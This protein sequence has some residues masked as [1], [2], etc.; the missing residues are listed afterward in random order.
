MKPRR[1]YRELGNTALVAAASNPKVI[2]AAGKAVPVVM[3]QQ[4]R[5]VNVGLIIT[6]TIVGGI[7]LFFLSR[8]AAKKQRERLLREAATN[9]NKKA[10]LDIFAAIPGR[11]KEDETNLFNPGK[12]ISDWFNNLAFWQ[13]SDSDRI[14]LVA[15]RITDL[16]ETARTFQILYGEALTPLLQKAMA[17]EDYDRFL[18]SAKRPK[19]FVQYSSSTANAGKIAGT[20]I[21]TTLLAFDYRGFKSYTIAAN[22]LINGYTTGKIYVDQYGQLSPPDTKWVEIENKYIKGKYGSNA[23]VKLSDVNLFPAT[24]FPNHQP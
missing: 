4:R 7:G 10:A 16:D 21:A 23:A 18:A 15:E 20:K 1:K 8:Y 6:G 17:P 5:M 9:P 14:L 24:Q 12:I 13:K 19:D 2:E 3:Q 22:R 11:F